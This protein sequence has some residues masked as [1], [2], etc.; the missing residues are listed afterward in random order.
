MKNP[1]TTIAGIAGLVVTL[2]AA[3]NLLL[4][5]DPKTMPDWNAVG[6]SITTSLGLIFAADGRRK[7][8]GD[9]PPK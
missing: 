3:A 5:G 9:E 8:N 7:P 4:D 2:G 1:L 6:V